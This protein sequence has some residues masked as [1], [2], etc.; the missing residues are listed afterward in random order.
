MV[1]ATC[2]SYLDLGL[3]VEQGGTWLEL[4]LKECGSG[5]NQSFTWPSGA[6]WVLRSWRPMVFGTLVP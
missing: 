1:L 6:I 2:H 3:I 5:R 4:W